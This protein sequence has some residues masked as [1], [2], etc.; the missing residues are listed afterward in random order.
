MSYRCG[1]REGISVNVPFS[2]DWNKAKR[3]VKKLICG[4][5]LGIQRIPYICF[6]FQ[7][8]KGLTKVIYG[9]LKR[10]VKGKR[11]GYG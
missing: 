10:A 6:I 7:G 9:M 4:Q 11:G 5:E 3:G 1:N 2:V 8:D